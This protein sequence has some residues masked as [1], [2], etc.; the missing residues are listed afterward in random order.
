MKLFWPVKNQVFNGAVE[1]NRI[2]TC[3][4]I[5]RKDKAVHFTD[6]NLMTWKHSLL[7]IKIKG[8]ILSVSDQL[9]CSW[10]KETY[11]RK[12]N[13]WLLSPVLLPKFC[14][15]TV[16]YNTVNFIF[17]VLKKEIR[18]TRQSKHAEGFHSW[19]V[20]WSDKSSAASIL[21]AFIIDFPAFQP[22]ERLGELS[23]KLA[24][25]QSRI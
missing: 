4:T 1:Q 16:K 14:K 6:R 25:D 9:L 11:M 18:G 19:C 10:L 13:F 20:W 23:L 24:L 17:Y 2:P 5:Q 15:Y 22:E 21:T 7:S 12:N 8:M 3:Y